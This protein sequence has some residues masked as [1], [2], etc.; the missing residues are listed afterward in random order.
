MK[1]PNVV[2]YVRERPWAILPGA[3]EAIVEILAMHELGERSEE[4]IRAALEAAR[5]AR[6][7]AAQRV[8]SLAVVPIYG[9]I[10]PRA[11]LFSDLSGGTSLEALRSDLD[12]LTRDESVRAIVLDVNSPGG[13]TE[14]LHET[15]GEIRKMR[16]RKPI[17]AVGN[18]MA[19]SAAYHLASQ[20][21]EFFITPSGMAGSVGVYATHQD[22]SAMQEKAGIKTTFIQAG[23]RKTEGNPFEPLSKE[24]EE[25]IQSLVDEHARLMVGD[26]AAGRR[27]PEADVSGERFG[28]GRMFHAAEATRRGMADGVQTFDTT[29]STLLATGVSGRATAPALERAGR[30]IEVA[31]VG[32]LGPEWVTL[33]PEQAAKVRAVAATEK[34][35]DETIET[36]VSA[37]DALVTGSERFPRLSRRKRERLEELAERITTRLAATDEEAVSADVDLAAAEDVFA[38]HTRR[39]IEGR[40]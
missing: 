13:S 33:M 40:L 16:E 9:A 30:P 23:R 14:L 5:P 32:E 37:L 8:G 25:Q 7:P 34:T 10:F 31:L 11:S 1:H 28:E 29:V 4:E 39:L 24:A 26:I 21:S 35:F 15:A 27:V 20:A 36:A 2:R 12:E 18:T 38:L 6:E 19:A 17:V 22:L 3:L